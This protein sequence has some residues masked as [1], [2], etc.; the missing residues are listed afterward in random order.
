MKNRKIV[1]G[2]PGAGKVFIPLL[3][4]EEWKKLR[5]SLEST[6]TP[7]TVWRTCDPPSINGPPEDDDHAEK[8]DVERLLRVVSTLRNNNRALEE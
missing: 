4:S 6:S 2:G 3:T 8:S 7:K 1:G 5:E